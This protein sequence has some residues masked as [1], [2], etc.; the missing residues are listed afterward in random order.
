MAMSNG[1]ETA[2]YSATARIFHWTTAAIVLTLL[3]AGLIMNNLPEGP[4][5]DFVYNLH[6]SLGATLIPLVALRIVWRLTHTPPPLPEDIPAIQRLAASLNHLALYMILAVQPILGWI[7][8]SAYRAPVIVFGMFELP[9]IWPENRVFSERLF[10]VHKFI[11]FAI[12][13]LIIAHV[14]AALY[15]HFVRRDD[16]LKRMWR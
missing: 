3:P 14:G 16:I 7:A 2:I 11:G 6:R 8:T 4:F 12:G 5:A 13:A 1:R 10:V 15:H 9:P